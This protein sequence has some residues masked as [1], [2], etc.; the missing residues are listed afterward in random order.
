M[1]KKEETFKKSGSQEDIDI[2][3]YSWGETGVLGLLMENFK[4]K[5]DIFVQQ[6]SNAQLQYL[7]K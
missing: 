4:I 3:S 2:S 6:A 5:P 1:V 7:F